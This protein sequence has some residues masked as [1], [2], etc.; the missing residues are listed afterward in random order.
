MK[1]LNALIIISF[2]FSNIITLGMAPTQMNP[3]Q[4]LFSAI[5]NSD[6][7]TVKGLVNNPML[8]INGKQNGVTP[9]HAAIVAGS[10]PEILALLLSNK[11]INVNRKSDYG[12]TPLHMATITTM[13]D[14]DAGPIEMLLAAGANPYIT[15]S[16]N[17]T[18][19][20]VATPEI[21]QTIRN[22]IGSEKKRISPVGL[23]PH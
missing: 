21:K 3:L 9:L 23:Y 20:D 12:E 22:F 8:D 7:Q 1:K 19:L 4:A 15:N 18:V 5:A 16:Q 2:L 14:E 11:N 6:V 10:N 13:F 17:K